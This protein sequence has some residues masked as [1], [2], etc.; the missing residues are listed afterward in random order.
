M[1]I[2]IVPFSDRRFFLF[3]YVFAEERL[4]FAEESG[5]DGHKDD[6]RDDG[7]NDSGSA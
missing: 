5:D 4:S 1:L 2:A 6:R 3:F 7:S